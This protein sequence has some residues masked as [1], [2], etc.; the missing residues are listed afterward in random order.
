MCAVVQIWAPGFEKRRIETAGKKKTKPH[1]Q[2][3]NFPPMIMK[4]FGITVNTRK[5]C[6]KEQTERGDETEKD[7]GLAQHGALQ[8]FGHFVGLKV[9]WLLLGLSFLVQN[10]KTVAS[11]GLLNAMLVCICMRAITQLFSKWQIYPFKTTFHHHN[12]IL[13]FPTFQRR[14]SFPCCRNKRETSSHTPR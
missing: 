9:F 10:S 13:A 5:P 3:Q 14:Y 1:K 12:L 4:V 6:T 2:T 8:Y 7:C 11:A